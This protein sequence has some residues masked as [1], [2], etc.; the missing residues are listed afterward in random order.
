M[1]GPVLVDSS[2][3]TAATRPGGD[4]KVQA[5]LDSGT[6]VLGGSAANT[7]SGLMRVNDG[8]LT[9][10]KSSGN[11]VV[12]SLEVGN[13]NGAAAS[14]VVPPPALILATYEVSPNKQSVVRSDCTHFPSV[15]IWSDSAGGEP[16]RS[17]TRL[18]FSLAEIQ[19]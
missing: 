15:G 5:E 12:G 6:M 3:W 2:A 7:F 19:V 13:G 18:I 11:A 16:S 1:S 9:L 14:T 4:S 8:Q 10:A 17:T